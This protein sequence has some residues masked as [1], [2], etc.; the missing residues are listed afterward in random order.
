MGPA[1]DATARGSKARMGSAPT[2]AQQLQSQGQGVKRNAS[3]Q[4]QLAE[5]GYRPPNRQQQM[6]GAAPQKQPQYCEE[7]YF[8]SGGGAPTQYGPFDLCSQQ[9]GPNDG[10]LLAA[11]GAYPGIGGTEPDYGFVRELKGL[12]PPEDPLAGPMSDAAATSDFGLAAEVS[13][14]RGPGGA[15]GGLRPGTGGHG[16]ILPLR[17]RKRMLAA[18]GPPANFGLS[19]ELARR[20]AQQEADAR[21]PFSSANHA[22]KQDPFLLASDVRF[23]KALQHQEQECGMEPLEG[24]DDYGLASELGLDPVRLHPET[25]RPAC[26][27]SACA[28]HSCSG[29]RVLGMLLPSCR[30]ARCG[31][32]LLQENE[33]IRCMHTAP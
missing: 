32:V 7:Q 5:A 12:G 19:E 10:P 26:W 31:G 14:R 3:T 30:H 8:S 28:E 22:S 15:L 6:Q 21:D 16:V 24:D 13:R 18:V 1:G 29:A 27:L 2:P 33:A 17:S 20:Q 23:P 11:G 9:I 4:Q 25:S